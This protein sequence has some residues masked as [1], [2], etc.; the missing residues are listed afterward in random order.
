VFRLAGAYLIRAEAY[1]WKNQLDLAANDINKVRARAKALLITASD[2]TIDYIFDERAR[3]LYTEE[4]RHSEMVRVSNIMAILNIGG[5]NLENFSQKNWWYDRL[6]RVNDIYDI[7]PGTWWRSQTPRIEP[8]NVYW[9][10]PQSVITANT[11]GT[12]NQNVGY[13]G[14]ENNVPPLETIE[15]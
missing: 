10:I 9:P 15:E 1:Y 6:M 7:P 13:V 8:Y 5:Y 3:E 14:A 2:V 11:L 12:I 4:P